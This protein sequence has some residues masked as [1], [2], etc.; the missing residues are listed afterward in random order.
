M[1]EKRDAFVDAMKRFFEYLGSDKARE[2]LEGILRLIVLGCE[3][4]EKFN[5]PLAGEEKARFVRLLVRMVKY[6]SPGEVE[7]LADLMLRLKASGEIDA[8]EAWELDKA[9]GDGIVGVMLLDGRLFCFT[10]E[11]PWR[12]NER[13]VSCI[14][15]GRYSALLVQSPRHGRCA[16]LLDVPGRSQ[17]LIHAGNRASDTEG[18]ILVGRWPGYIAG[19]RVVVFSRAALDLLL[20]AL[21]RKED[22]PI[23]VRVSSWPPAHG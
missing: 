21:A 22:E 16:Q 23:V 17:I 7:R 10:L 1:G 3:I 20:E 19:Q 12:N 6:A 2:T 4:A 5:A 9:L 13:N 11:P 14:P 15:E 8:L 18:C